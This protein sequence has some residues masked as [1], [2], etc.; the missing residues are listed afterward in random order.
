ML[1]ESM[2][3]RSDNVHI[4]PL[5]FFCRGLEGPARI[6]CFVQS[7]GS[8]RTTFYGAVSKTCA[9]EMGSYILSTPWRCYLLSFLD[10]NSAHQISINDDQ[11]LDDS[12]RKSSPN[13]YVFQHPQISI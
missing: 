13:S 2:S 10:Y 7:H 6:F 4:F 5:R 12:G 11:Y 9:S 1:F 3:T 8:Y